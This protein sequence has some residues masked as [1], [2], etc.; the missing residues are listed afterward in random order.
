MLLLNII[1]FY[2]II[3]SFFLANEEFVYLFSILICL[4]FFPNVINSFYIKGISKQFKI[5]NFF[6]LILELFKT[7]ILKQKK[8]INFFYFKQR[9]II[10]SLKFYFVLCQKFLFFEFNNLKL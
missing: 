6:Y 1:C 3:S 7:K 4:H 2:L 10:L 9:I 8:L 5:I